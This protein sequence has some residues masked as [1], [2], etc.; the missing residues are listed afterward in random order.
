MTVPGGQ[1]RAAGERSSAEGT[2]TFTIVAVKGNISQVGIQIYENALP[3]SGE[4]PDLY[5][6]CASCPDLREAPGKL[7]W[8]N[9]HRPEIFPGWFSVNQASEGR[10]RSVHRP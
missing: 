1:V 3:T 7:L 9:L 6:V 2:W 8:G 10:R 5:V 4:D